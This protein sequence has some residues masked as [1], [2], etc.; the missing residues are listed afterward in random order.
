MTEVDPIVGPGHT[1][2]LVFILPDDGREPYT[3][4]IT[5]EQVNPGTD[6]AVTLPWIP[7][8]DKWWVPLTPLTD[9]E[10]KHR[11]LESEYDAAINALG[12]ARARLVTNTRVKLMKAGLTAEEADLLLEG[13]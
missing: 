2:E 12:D 6:G 5:Y 8:E 7:D 4:R 9:Y 10:E 11:G 3:V 1:D 13:K